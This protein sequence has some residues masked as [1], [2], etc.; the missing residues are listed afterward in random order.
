MVY[1]GLLWG[2]WGTLAYPVH[3]TVRLDVWEPVGAE[4]IGSDLSSEVVISCSMWHSTLL[5]IRWNCCTGG[6]CRGIAVGLSGLN[7][8]SGNFKAMTI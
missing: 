2:G 1:G 5:G 6:M 7:L 4:T 3:L 8:G